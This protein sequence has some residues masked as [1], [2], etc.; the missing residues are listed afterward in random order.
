MKFNLNINDSTL[1]K[2]GAVAGS[3]PIQSDKVYKYKADDYKIHPIAD[4]LDGTWTCAWLSGNSDPTS[5]PIWVDRF[6]NPNF[7]TEAE[8]L[9]GGTPIVQFV[10]TFESV[11]LAVGASS[12][13]VFDVLSDLVFSPGAPLML[14]KVRHYY[15]Y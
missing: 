3:L 13:Y 9:G 1:V 2:S 11:T 12:L 6:F 14:N 4:Q 5:T 15:E 7:I 8:A 10:D